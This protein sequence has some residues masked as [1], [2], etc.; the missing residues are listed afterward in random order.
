MSAAK[1]DVWRL[2]SVGHLENIFER[3]SLIVIFVIGNIS[4]M[5]IR[6]I[7]DSDFFFDRI[8]VLKFAH[9]EFLVCK[10]ESDEFYCCQ[11]FFVFQ[12]ILSDL[13]FRRKFVVF[14][15]RNFHFVDKLCAF[16]DFRK[17]ETF[18]NKL[19]IPGQESTKYKSVRSTEFALDIF[20]L[21]THSTSRF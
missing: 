20:K 2:A 16:Y 18:R 9:F 7:C 19:F 6:R 11:F 14:L 13:D 5:R 8:F 17:Q 15:K 4:F 10:N 1:A 12:K 21:H 3:V